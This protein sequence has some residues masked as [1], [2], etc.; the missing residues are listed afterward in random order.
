LI[1]VGT[2]NRYAERKV[3]DGCNGFGKHYGIIPLDNG[4]VAENDSEL[5]QAFADQAQ[6]L[7]FRRHRPPPGIV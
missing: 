4:R 2:Q 1:S 5:E 7:G 3:Y 6:S